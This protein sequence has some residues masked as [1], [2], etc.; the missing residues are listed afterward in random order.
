MA[1]C[2]ISK[3]YSFTCADKKKA[4]G[5]LK[6]TVWLFNTIDLESISRNG[7]NEVSSLNFTP[8]ANVYKYEGMRLGNRLT[9]DMA[10]TDAGNSYY[11]IT[12]AM[13][14]IDITQAQRDFYEDLSQAESI[15]MVVQSSQDVFE[16]TGHTVGLELTSGP[17][18]T[19][20][21]TSDAVRILNLTGNET[22][23]PQIVNAGS[24]SDTL[25]MLNSYT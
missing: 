15:G 25:A 6:Q 4:V 16:L 13:Q 17:R 23:P 9:D 20:D 19:S 5:G 8:Y 7:S 2:G 14:M 11:P 1:N 12:F 18:D 3:A 24:V 22:S 10:K 21:P